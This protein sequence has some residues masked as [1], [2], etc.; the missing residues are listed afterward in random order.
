[1]GV[2]AVIWRSYFGFGV[3]L[4][5][6]V[7]AQYEWQPRDAFD[8]IRVKMDKV[9]ADNCQ[10]QHLG[11]LYL[12]DDSVSHLIDIKEVNINPVFPNRTALLHLHNMA[13]SRSFFWSYILQSRFIRPAIND[14]YDPGMMYYFLSTVADVSANPFIN[15]SAVYFSP[16]SSYTSSYRGFFNKTFPRFAPRTFR[17][18]DFNDPIHLQKISTMN[19]FDVRDLGAIPAD[20]LSKDYTTDFYKINEWFRLWLPDDVENRHDTKTTYQVEIRYANNTNETFTFHGPRGADENP[21]PV[22][23]TRPYFDCGRSN[24][25]LVAAVVPIADIYPRHTQVLFHIPDIYQTFIFESVYLFNYNTSFYSNHCS[26]GTLNIQSKCSIISFAI[27]IGCLGQM[28]THAFYFLSRYTAV[29][30]L[31]MDYERIDINQCPKGEGN[32]GPNKFA[33]TARCKKES[34]ECEPIHGWGLRRGGYQCRC[35]PGFRLPNHV[36]RPFLG[37]IIERAS[38]EQYYNGFDCLKIGCTYKIQSFS[39]FY[40]IFL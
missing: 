26:S 15:A 34:T 22:K 30:V 9:T 19:T 23:F 31:E 3:L 2:T 8:E 16:N 37:E 6:T 18:D 27:D 29:S 10:I 4:C 17:M 35:K 33:D 5:V 25:W 12:P 32:K 13:L 14:T 38:A 20:S 24:K 36:R 40:L 11:D 39:K 21:G 1:M 28:K 7:L